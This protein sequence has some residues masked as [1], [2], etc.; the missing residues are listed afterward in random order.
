[1][2]RISTA[3]LELAA[4]TAAATPITPSPSSTVSTPSTTGG[5]LPVRRKPHGPLLCLSLATRS[6]SRLVAAIVVGEKAIS[7]P[8]SDHNSTGIGNSPV[9]LE[10]K[11]R[12]TITDV[13]EKLFGDSHTIRIT[14]MDIE[15]LPDQFIC[16]REAPL[17]DGSTDELKC[18]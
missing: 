5:E 1:M 11:R 16:P 12:T 4:V 6:H 14:D 10:R 2:P 7:P 18:G 13:K 17:M 15:A 9:I 3:D 8:A